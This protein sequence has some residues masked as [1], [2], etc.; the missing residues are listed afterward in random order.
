[1]VVGVARAIAG[2][3]REMSCYQRGSGPK[4]PQFVSAILGLALRVLTGEVEAWWG[5]N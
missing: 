4:T 5:N 2:Q 1:M 3:R